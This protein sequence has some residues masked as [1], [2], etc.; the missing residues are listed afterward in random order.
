MLSAETFDDLNR[1]RM[2]GSGNHRNPRF[3]N[4]PF[5][6]SN[7]PNGTSQHVGMVSAD[8][9]DH[10]DQ[11][12]TDVGRIQ[13]AAESH[14]QHCQ[15]DLLLDKVLPGKRGGQ[16]KCCW[17]HGAGLLV[18]LDEDGHQTIDQIQQFRG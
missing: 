1:I 11:R 14:L 17:L 6:S 3:D 4:P 16:F 9:C 2:G 18:H 13:S 10:S 7:L 12:S 15:V 5:F 8:I